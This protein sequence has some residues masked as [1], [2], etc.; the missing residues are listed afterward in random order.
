M[1][2]SLYVYTKAAWKSLSDPLHSLAQAPFRLSDGF[3]RPQHGCDGEAWEHH[4]LWKEWS[5]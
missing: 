1:L 4:N 5:R 3:R 2:G